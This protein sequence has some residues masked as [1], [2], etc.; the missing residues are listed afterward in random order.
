VFRDLLGENKPAPSETS[1]ETEVSFGITVANLTAEQ[2]QQM[3]YEEPGGVVVTSVEPGSFADDIGIARND[4]IAAI[5]R[6]NIS[7]VQDVR[8]IRRDLKAGSDVVFRVLRRA[9]AGAGRGNR[10]QSLFLAGVL[11]SGGQ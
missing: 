3:E 5:N 11:P 6:H 2:R 9:G 4:V 1:A 8:S 7:G 10:W